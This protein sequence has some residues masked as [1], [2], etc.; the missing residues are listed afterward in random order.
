MQV[1]WD[2][3]TA[4]ERKKRV[5]LWDIEPLTFPY[6]LCPQPLAFRAKRPRGGRGEGFGLPC[7]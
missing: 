6:V 3:S 7:L 4:A 1:G 5:S 2:E